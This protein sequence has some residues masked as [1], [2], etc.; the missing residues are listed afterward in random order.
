MTGPAPASRTI[1]ITIPVADVARSTAFFGKLGFSFNPAFSDGANGACMLVGEHAVV[2]LASHDA[3]AEHSHRPMCDPTTHAQ[4]L[5][6]FSV[7]TRD[8]VDSVSA[9]ALAEGATEADGAEDH[10]SMYT[11]SFF[12]LDGHGWQVMWMDPAVA[13]LGAVPE[14]VGATA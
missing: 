14:G 10:G 13:Q 5:F 6:S 2:M 12:D 9:A 3:F 11:R 8:E 7:A 4:A 1:A